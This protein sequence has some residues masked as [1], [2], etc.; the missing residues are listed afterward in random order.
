MP[1]KRRQE[2][3]SE[4]DD[5]MPMGGMPMDFARF[6][7]PNYAR[8]FKAKLPAKIRDRV[9][10]LEALDEDYKKMKV[11]M[12]KLVDAAE[13]EYHKAIVP[14]AERRKKILSG[15]EE[16]TEEEVQ[17]GF[18]EEHKE[19]GVT[20]D[21]TPDTSVKGIDS[22]WLEALQ[23]HVIIDEFI[24]ERDAEALKYVTDIRSEL[25]A[26]GEG[27][28]FTIVFEFAENPFFSNNTLTK[29]FSLTRQSDDTVVSKSQGT[30]I[31]W[32]EGKN[33]T[34]EVK[35][36]K[37][38]PKGKKGPPKFVTEEVPCES[39]F[40]FFGDDEDEEEEWMAFAET[41]K[42]KIIPFAVDYFTGEAPNG[43]SDLEDDEEGEVEE[44][45]EEEEEM[46][47]KRGGGGRGGYS[48]PAPGGKRG[49]AGGG[50]GGAGNQQDC[51]Q[52]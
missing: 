24:T 26:D 44:E 29:K 3:E 48:A 14:F 27:D 28:G 2:P 17:Q 39:I 30:T 45:E 12:S 36:K 19:A 47:P 22:F 4:S 11:E 40:H 52:Q 37:L 1:P 7:N 5:G 23:H 18:D 35:S 20:L 42:D 51:K 46:P 9:K 43:E 34:V 16:P 13:R 10:A 41:L 33:L 6:T 25:S 38:K 31:E 49:G 32:K 21:G 8:E 50:R 15:A